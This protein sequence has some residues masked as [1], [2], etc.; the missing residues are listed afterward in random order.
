M[1]IISCSCYDLS[2]N[3]AQLCG[4]VKTPRAQS[5]KC[6]K[7]AGLW[8]CEHG[9]SGVELRM[10]DACLICDSTVFQT[11]TLKNLHVNIFAIFNQG[12]NVSN[13]IYVSPNKRW[14]HLF[15]WISASKQIRSKQI[16][17]DVTAAF[18]RQSLRSALMLKATGLIFLLDL[19]LEEVEA[20]P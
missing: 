18:T 13:T 16:T 1:L 7:C 4:G 10:T 20:V 12:E 6:F 19:F 8:L 2:K 17:D 5:F 9:L 14:G 15:G 3:P 11:L